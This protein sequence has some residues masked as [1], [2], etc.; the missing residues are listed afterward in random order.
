[1]NSFLPAW[2][3]ISK[4]PMIIKII[5]SSP[6]RSTLLR[7]GIMA[8]KRPATGGESCMQDSPPVEKQPM[9]YQVRYKRK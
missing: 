5:K 1:M 4:I 8:L 7:R 9:G 6:G 3:K 2:N